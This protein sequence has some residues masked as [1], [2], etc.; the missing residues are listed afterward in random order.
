MQKIK[1][2]KQGSKATNPILCHAGDALLGIKT[3]SMPLAPCL[4]GDL[5]S[6]S[7]HNVASI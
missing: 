2:E 4:T 7:I 3:W 5:M 1:Q 6:C